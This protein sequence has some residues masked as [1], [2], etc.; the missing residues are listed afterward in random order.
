M[1]TLRDRTIINYRQLFSKDLDQL[2]VLLEL[3]EEIITECKPVSARG[4]NIA[5]AVTFRQLA[6]I[7]A[8]M[9]N[10]SSELARRKGLSKKRRKRDREDIQQDCLLNCQPKPKLARTSIKAFAK[11][12]HKKASKYS[13]CSSGKN[14]GAKRRRKGSS[15]TEE[16]KQIAEEDPEKL[17][18]QQTK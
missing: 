7:N 11:S 15:K 14:R 6:F 4:F 2:M 12:S 1:A 5:K 18:A 13:T 16:T 17:N 9:G 8:T 3:K 10:I